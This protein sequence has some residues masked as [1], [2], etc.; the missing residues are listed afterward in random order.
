[1]CIRSPALLLP[2][3]GGGIT[4]IRGSV[5]VTLRSRDIVLAGKTALVGG[6]LVSGSDWVWENCRFGNVDFMTVVVE[7]S[8]KRLA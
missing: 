1:M 6:S 2:P 7:S 5:K 3:A 8:P 4:L